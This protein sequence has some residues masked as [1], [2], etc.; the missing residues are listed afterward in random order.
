MCLTWTGRRGWG[1]PAPRVYVPLTQVGGRLLCGLLPSERPLAKV[2]N[3]INGLKVGKYK[4]IV[5]ETR[6]FFS[7]VI[8]SGVFFPPLQFVLGFAGV[9]QNSLHHPGEGERVDFGKLCVRHWC[10][11]TQEFHAAFLA[12]LFICCSA[13]GV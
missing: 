1:F 10:G 7:K 8:T 3:W 11:E 12:M 6:Y 5:R 2:V 9:S 4:E 13:C